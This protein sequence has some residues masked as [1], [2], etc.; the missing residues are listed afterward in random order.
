MERKDLLKGAFMI[1]EVEHT[2]WNKEM[3][4]IQW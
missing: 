4:N 2:S 3:Y 1:F